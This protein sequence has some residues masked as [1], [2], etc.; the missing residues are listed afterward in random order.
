MAPEM[1]FWHKIFNLGTPKSLVVHQNGGWP[2]KEIFGAQCA[3]LMEKG[4]FSYEA[5]THK[6]GAWVPILNFFPFFKLV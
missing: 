1:T 5:P 4:Q 2:M 3:F 6:N